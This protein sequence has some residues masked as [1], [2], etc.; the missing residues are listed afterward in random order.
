MYQQLKTFVSLA[1]ILMIGSAVFGQKSQQNTIRIAKVNGKQIQL[2]KK[3]LQATFKDGSKL[4]NAFIHQIKDRYVLVR[5]LTTIK[6]KTAVLF[7][8]VQK[9]NDFIHIK[10]KPIKP[11]LWGCWMSVSCVDCHMP[12]EWGQ[13]CHCGG[14]Q[15]EH[16]SCVALEDIND[17]WNEIIDREGPGGF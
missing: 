7:S 15:S 8:P 3:A 17:D 13:T 6:G 14:Q 2:R 16:D 9:R 10:I 11:I 12:R 5:E 4:T 1:L